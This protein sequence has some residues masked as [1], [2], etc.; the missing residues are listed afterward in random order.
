[1]KS[2]KLPHDAEGL[3][4]L[5]AAPG[6]ELMLR[7]VSTQSASIG[8]SATATSGALTATAGVSAGGSTSQAFTKQLKVLENDTV[9]FQL[10]QTDARSAGV[11]VGATAGTNL[12]GTVGNAVDRALRFRVAG[13]A[14]AG[15]SDKVMG[16][17][18]LDLKTPQGV[19]ALDYLLKASPEAGAEYIQRNHLGAT[20][21]GSTTG[22]SSALDVRFG[23]TTLLS[24][25]TTRG[26]T[27]GVIEEPGGTTLLSTADYGRDVGGVLPRF[28]MGEERSVAVKAGELTRNGVT[29]RALGVSLSVKAT[30]LKGP[31]LE[32]CRRCGT[33]LG[34]RGSGL[35]AAG[36]SD[37]GRA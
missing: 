13:Q 36:S 10:T 2:L 6:S 18:V 21:A 30:E 19:A 15:S 12:S 22:S 37:L 32:Q 26:T 24:S 11:S 33:A 34:A 7:G 29:Q 3:K 20:Y 5:A 35:P 23:S 31:E 4:K 14:N 8:A 25:S 9:F 28:F 17:V 16:A 27:S 1:L